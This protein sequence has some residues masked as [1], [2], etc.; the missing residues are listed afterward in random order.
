MFVAIVAIATCVVVCV[1]LHLTILRLL[2]RS[3]SAGPG[4]RRNIHIALLVLGCIVAHIIEIGVF[5][6]GLF[7]VAEYDGDTRIVL[8]GRQHNNLDLWYFSACY[9]TSL[10]AERNPPSAGLRVFTAC[11]AVVGLILITWT[12]SFLFLLMQEVWAPKDR[13]TQIPPRELATN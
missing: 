10:G 4:P 6:I 7:A 13:P 2:W 1:G 3:T 12:A 11:E 9:F 5:S 8:E